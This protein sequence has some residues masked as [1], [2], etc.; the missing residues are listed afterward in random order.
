MESSIFTADM[1]MVVGLVAVTIFFFLTEWIRVDVVAMLV[2]VTLPLLGIIDGSQAF[3]GLSS[4]AVISIIAVI[5]MGRGLDHTGV[6][7]KL[8]KPLMRLAGK[9]RNRIILLIASTVAVI[10]SFMQNVGA[11]ALFLPAIRRLSRNAE[12][13]VSQLL[14]PIGFAAILGGTVTLVGSSPLIMLN[15]LIAPYDLPPFNLFSVTPIGIALVAVGIAYFSIT[16]SALLPK[17]PRTTAVDMHHEDPMIYYPE[18]G[19]LH[20]LRA[21]ANSDSNGLTV[22]DLCETYKLHVVA[23]GFNDG[24]DVMIP[25]DRSIR[26]RHNTV[27]AVYGKEERVR[28]FARKYNFTISPKV[29]FFAETLSDDNAGVVEALIPPHSK[30]IGMTFSDIRFRHNHLMAPL[31]HTREN[32]TAYCCF[33][34]TIAHAGDSLLMHGTWESFKSMR[35]TRD[36][37]FVQSLD[38]EVLHP[39]LAWRAIGAFMLATIL[40]IFS[41]LA[42]SVCLMTGALG[43]ILSRVL[44]IDEAYRGIDWRTVFLLGGLIPLGVAMQSTGTAQWAAHN[45][46]QLVG[47]PPPAVFLFIVGLVSTLFSLV[48]S[49]VGAA[50]LLIPLVIDMA[51]QTGVDPRLAAFVVA[52]A[53]SNSFVLPTHQVNALYMGPGGYKSLDFLKAGAP[54]TVLFLVVL[55]T[56][57]SLFY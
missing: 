34:D 54:L 50:V 42:L 47:S 33:W 24:V 51:V 13:P 5:I 23:L 21:P 26:L 28:E 57:V 31:T 3:A 43:M 11:A 46:M 32:H 20:E 45:F 15:D 39:E 37:L 7:S 52:V 16:G 55:T 14:M 2:M 48:V 6:V 49:N 44:T 38:H 25:P 36:M 19:Q 41:D 1:G 35:P 22:L 29:E 40:V 56:M 30:F 53:S 18:L 9:S 4:N 8:V 17:A 12:I 27:I 10:S